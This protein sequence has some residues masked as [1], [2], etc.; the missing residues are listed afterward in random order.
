MS[1]IS[2]GIRGAAAATALA[3]LGTASL[4]LWTLYSRH[5]IP[6]HKP[7]PSSSS[8]TKGTKR[9]KQNDQSSISSSRQERGSYK[10]SLLLGWAY[11][12]KRATML[13]HTKVAAHQV[14]LSLWLVFALVLDGAS[15]AAQVL[16][17]RTY[18]SYKAM[19]PHDDSHDD[20]SGIDC[21]DWAHGDHECTHLVYLVCIYHH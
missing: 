10:G 7:P 4:Y 8:T 13:G 11:A 9:T 14:A 1:P 5:M 2:F 3:Q 17:A 20:G 19:H 12:T 6:R 15:V 21:V 18:N 16:M